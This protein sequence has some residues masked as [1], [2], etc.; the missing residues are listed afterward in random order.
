MESPQVGRKNPPRDGR[1]VSLKALEKFQCNT[2]FVSPTT[3]K[4]AYATPQ[5]SEWK[6]AE[7]EELASI[8]G[9]HV[10]KLHHNREPQNADAFLAQNA[11][12][13]TDFS[14]L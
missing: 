5:Q 3:Q 1:G 9:Q 7:R 6:D 8:R 12:I 11:E 13:N 2:A 4:M 14:S 10:W